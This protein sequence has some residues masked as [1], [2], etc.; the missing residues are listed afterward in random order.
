MIEI[1]GILQYNINAENEK[2][3]AVTQ[4]ENY[5]ENLNVTFPNCLI[6]RIHC[7]YFKKINLYE[8]DVISAQTYEA[9]L[10]KNISLGYFKKNYV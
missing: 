1:Y 10:H 3:G 9:R 8:T 2:F 5:L 6:P 7:I 4:D